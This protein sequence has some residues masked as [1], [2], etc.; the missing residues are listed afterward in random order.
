MINKINNNHKNYSYN[1]NDFIEKKKKKKKKK[2]K[3]L[4]IYIIFIVL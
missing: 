2:K 4:K 3:T 1:L